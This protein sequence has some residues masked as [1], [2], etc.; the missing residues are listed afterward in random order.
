MSVPTLSEI[1]YALKSLKDTLDLVVHRQEMAETDIKE[2]ASRGDYASAASTQGMK[3]G[4]MAAE[5]LLRIEIETLEHR[6]LAVES[7]LYTIGAQ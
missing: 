1:D 2:Q 4:L 3:T 6:R 7:Y 5:T